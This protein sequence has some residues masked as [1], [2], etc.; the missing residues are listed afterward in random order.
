MRE[1]ALDRAGLQ[2][3]VRTGPA[4]RAPHKLFPE[5]LRHGGH[6]ERDAAAYCPA[7][8]GT[9]TSTS[10]WATRP[11]IRRKPST[12]TAHSSPGAASCVPA[13][14]T[15]PRPTRNGMSSSAIS[16]AAGSPSATAAALTAPAHPR[17]QLHP[18][19]ALR[20]DP[21]QRTRLDPSMRTS[22]PDCRGGAQGWAGE[23]EGLKVSLAAATAKLIEMD[24][25]VS[26]AHG[27]RARHA[28][29][30]RHCQPDRHRPRPA[31]LMTAAP[32][33]PS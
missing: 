2:G 1:G 32:R 24:E 9:G 23:A 19:F 8:A 29:L 31:A 13:R 14:N 28:R 7:R 21:A 27:R 22:G 17:A 20:L 18:L 4:V 11:S 16:S 30:S 10:L 6:D 15:G 3:H 5:I 12:P 33:R 26:G 25:L